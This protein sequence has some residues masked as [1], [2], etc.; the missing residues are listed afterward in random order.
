MKNVVKMRCEV[1]RRK[2]ENI[3]IND[4]IEQSCTE[5]VVHVMRWKMQH[6][7]A[8]MSSLNKMKLGKYLVLGTTMD[9]VLPEPVWEGTIWTELWWRAAVGEV[10]RLSNVCYAHSGGVKGSNRNLHDAWTAHVA[11]NLP[12]AEYQGAGLCGRGCKD[13]DGAGNRKNS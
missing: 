9:A 6:P 11:F 13:E 3:D 2:G 8:G 4:M 10:Q 12:H 1:R 5:I 7:I